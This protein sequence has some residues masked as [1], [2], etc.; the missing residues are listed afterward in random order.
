MLCVLHQQNPGWM[1]RE[2]QSTP[3]NTWVSGLVTDV[4]NLKGRI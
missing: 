1:E 3:S 2:V 4:N